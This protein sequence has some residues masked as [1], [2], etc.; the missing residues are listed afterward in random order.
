[1]QV[2][3]RIE[4]CSTLILPVTFILHTK[5]LADLLQMVAGDGDAAV[6]RWAWRGEAH[7]SEDGSSW[8][9]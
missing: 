6:D 2:N 7:R 8:R 3:G 9:S 5:N 4:P 1:M